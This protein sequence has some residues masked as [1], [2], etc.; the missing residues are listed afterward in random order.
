MKA[1]LLRQTLQHNLSF[2]RAPSPLSL[3]AHPAPANLPQAMPLIVGTYL[4]PVI[5]HLNPRFRQ[6]FTHFD[7]S[8]PNILF[9]F[10]LLI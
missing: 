7:F 10:L 5:P 3:P 1:E 9:D 6:L 8:C 4:H 2:W